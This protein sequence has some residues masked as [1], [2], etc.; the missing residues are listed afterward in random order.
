MLKIQMLSLDGCRGEGAVRAM[1][2]FS[3]LLRRPW[4]RSDSIETAAIR[5]LSSGGGVLALEPAAETG[6][7]LAVGLLI[8]GYDAC[9]IEVII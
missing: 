7:S 4:R 3:D 8:V 2:A 9:H 5:R 6:R 1:A